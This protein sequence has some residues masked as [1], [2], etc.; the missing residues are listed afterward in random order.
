MVPS[1]DDVHG[2]E[3]C[4]FQLNVCVPL[5]ACT[6]VFSRCYRRGQLADLPVLNPAPVTLASLLYGYHYVPV[7]LTTPPCTEVGRIQ[8][9]L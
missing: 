8:I 2:V 5:S 9:S 1:L 6:L 4:I 3:L 7:Q